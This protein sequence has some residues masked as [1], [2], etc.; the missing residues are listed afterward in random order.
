MITYNG[1][2]YKVV[3]VIPAGR[4]RYLKISIPQIL[5]QDFVDEVRLWFN[6]KSIE[7]VDYVKS[8]VN[9]DPRITLDDLGLTDSSSFTICKFYIHCLD[10]DTIYV[11]LD[12][13]IIF[14]DKDYIHNIVKM[15]IEHKEPFV[16]FGNII[17]NCRMDYIHQEK[18]VWTLPEPV[19]DKA[20][21]S[22]GWGRGNSAEAKHRIFIKDLNNNDVEKYKHFDFKQLGYEKFSINSFAFFGKDFAE[23]NGDVNSDEE[24]FIGEAKPKSIGR[25]NAVCGKALCVHFAFY[26]QRDHLNTTDILEQYEHATSNYYS[27]KS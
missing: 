27:D 8:L 25:P 16:L 24:V 18:G 6:C 4:Q 7:D 12:D 14:I 21:C 13:D 20:D 17:N 11:R 19:T 3:V 9:L 26:T 15:R 1:E 5:K 2:T 22:I 23:F 10:H